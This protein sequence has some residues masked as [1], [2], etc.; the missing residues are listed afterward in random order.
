MTAAISAHRGG[1]EAAPGGT[2]DAY[3]HA[4]GIGADYV[5]F[6]VRRT[7]DGELVVYHDARPPAGEALADICY[8]RLSDLAGYDRWLAAPGVDVVVTDHPAR[9]IALRD[10][11]RGG[12]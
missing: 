7:A 9:A 11:L 4:V 5:E 2:Y 10:R 8:A 1:S 6:D 3:R 12:A